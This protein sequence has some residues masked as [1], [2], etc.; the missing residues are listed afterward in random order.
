MVAASDNVAPQTAPMRP[1]LIVREAT[2]KIETVLQGYAS[3]AGEVS[4]AL[5]QLKN[6]LMSPI[7][8]QLEVEEVA[9]ASSSS[10]LY[11]TH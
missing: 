9:T 10:L 8:P 3:V 4:D 2:K 1:H 11:V 7:L 6:Q 5:L